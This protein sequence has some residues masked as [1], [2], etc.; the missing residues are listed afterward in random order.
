MSKPIPY[1]YRLKIVSDR[2]SGLTFKQIAQNRGFSLRGVKKIWKQYQLFGEAGL[3]TRY[4]QSGRKSPYDQKTRDLIAA[5][6]DAKP[7][8]PYLHSILMEQ[9]PD[10]ELPHVRTIQRWWKASTTDSGAQRQK[11]KPKPD[12][13]EWTDEVHHT[14]QIDGKEK[15]KLKNGQQV[16]WLNIADEASSSELLAGVFSPV[17]Q[18]S[19]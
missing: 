13:S 2:E 8:A 4:H 19:G 7:G 16:S 17:Q 15:V 3:Q 5:G 12:K 14:W 11:G 1:D 6:R 18:E 9:Y 10:W